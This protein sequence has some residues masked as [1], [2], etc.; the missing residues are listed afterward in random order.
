MAI[1]PRLRN[2]P[3]AAPDANGNV[4]S[5][6]FEHDGATP[7]GWTVDS[8][9]NLES[10]L[11]WHADNP[12]LLF[13]TGFEGDYAFYCPFNGDVDLN[14][15]LVTPEI[16]LPEG[17]DLTSFYM[18]TPSSFSA[19]IML[20]GTPMNI[21]APR[22][23]SAILRLKYRPTAERHGTIYTAPSNR[24]KTNL[25]KN[26]SMSRA[27]R[28]NRFPSASPNMPARRLR[29]LSSAREKTPILSSS[30]LCA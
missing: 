17:W 21:S 10:D 12:A 14:E 27:S 2:L 1:T 26:C 11:T 29:S 13:M 18:P 7:D 8:K 3:A 4:L 23:L 19:W 25:S 5:E 28:L 30:T 20:I 6:N 9:N 15:W 22:S 24:A 16:E